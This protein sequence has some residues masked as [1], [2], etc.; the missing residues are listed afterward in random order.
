MI[1]TYYWNQLI[2]KDGENYLSRENKIIF[3]H[4]PL[5]TTFYHINS[6]K[7]QSLGPEKESFHLSHV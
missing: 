6:S 3:W 1:Y 4:Y 7:L 5:L 2:V